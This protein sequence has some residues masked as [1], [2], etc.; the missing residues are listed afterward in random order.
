MDASGANLHKIGPGDNPDFSPDGTQLVVDSGNPQGSVQVM[1][2]DGSNRRAIAVGADAAWS[3]DGKRIVFARQEVGF[4]SPYE[5]VT[6]LL[7]VAVDGSGEV[8]VTPRTSTGQCE[9]KD[10]DPDWQPVHR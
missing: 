9:F 3:P 6:R 1:N 2:I 4:C 7:S 5:R 10:S 8:E